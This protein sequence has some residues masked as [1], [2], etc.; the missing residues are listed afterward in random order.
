LF[1]KYLKWD[2]AFQAN[3]NTQT[4]TIK[5]S[6]QEMGGLPV[7][8]LFFTYFAQSSLFW[9]TILWIPMVVKSL[10]FTGTAQAMFSALPFFACLILGYPV[11][12]LSDRTGKRVLVTSLGL[13]IPGAILMVL[14]HIVDPVIKMAIITLAFSYCVSSFLPNIWSIIQS[15]VKPVA[16]GSTAGVANSCGALGGVVAGF[17]VGWL[18]NLT[19]SYTPGYVY[20]GVMVM[21]AGVAIILHD[22]YKRPL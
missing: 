2:P 18:Y 1:I 5:Y 7:L 9:G 14:P 6:F 13:I 15:S 12:V 22:R 3:G 8:L 21:L 10:N 20:L 4:A 11:S 19:G 16:V 17:V